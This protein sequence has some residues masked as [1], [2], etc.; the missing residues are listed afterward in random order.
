[1]Q[2]FGM[3]DW[4]N[5]TRFPA[6]CSPPSFDLYTKESVHL[7]ASVNKAFLW[8]LPKFRI[9]I[10]RL[11]RIFANLYISPYFSLVHLLPPP[12]HK[13]EKKC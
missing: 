12:Y 1:M 8:R 7:N 3:V 5:M 2:L 11:L 4:F 13:I 6:P 9:R 10:P